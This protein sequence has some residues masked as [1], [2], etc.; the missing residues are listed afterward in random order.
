MTVVDLRS[1]QNFQTNSMLILIPSTQ[2]IQLTRKTCHCLQTESTLMIDLLLCSNSLLYHVQEIFNI[3]YISRFDSRPFFV[4]LLSLQ[5]QQN[6][7][8]QM[9]VTTSRIVL[10]IFEYI[11]RILTI[12]SLFSIYLFI[13]FS[14]VLS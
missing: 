12:G 2:T 1:F 13:L 14:F 9:L 4:C 5:R 11:I 3:H 6:Y 7:F 8:F 10:R